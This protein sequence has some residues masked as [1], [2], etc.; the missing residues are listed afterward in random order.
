ME[1]LVSRLS[2]IPLKCKLSATHR[3]IADL[4]VKPEI[5]SQPEGA[6]ARIFLLSANI[7]QAVAMLPDR[8]AGRADFSECSKRI[9][10]EVDLFTYFSTENSTV[11]TVGG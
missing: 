11:M 3:K 10:Y 7:G 2:P 8:C 5:R 1:T 6:L 9:L 4:T